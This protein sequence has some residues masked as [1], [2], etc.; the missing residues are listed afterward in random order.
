LIRKFPEEHDNL[1]LLYD[2]GRLK[3]RFS[4]ITLHILNESKRKP[5]FMAHL[6]IS[7]INNKVRDI[8]WYEIEYSLSGEILDN[9]F[10]FY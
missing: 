1:H 3:F 8:A 2:E 4:G 10:D 7:D 5:F 9:Y 6:A